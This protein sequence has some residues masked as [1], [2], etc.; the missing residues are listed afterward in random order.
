MKTSGYKTK[1]KI[2]SATIILSVAYLWIS[3]SGE[4]VVQDS[5]KIAGLINQAREALQGKRFWEKQLLIVDKELEW[6]RGEPKRKARIDREIKELDREFD[7]DQEQFYRE[8]PDTRPSA[9]ER[10]AEILRERADVIEQAEF[11]RELEQWRL[12][13][14]DELQKIK[15]VVEVKATN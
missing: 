4:V 9:A 13:R 14:I 15:R 6:E 3:H 2:F 10:Q 5:G 7:K 12:Q 11:E 1:I 8:Y